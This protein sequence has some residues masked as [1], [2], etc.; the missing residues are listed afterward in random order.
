MTLWPVY[1]D[2]IS[3]MSDV[4]YDS[5][6]GCTNWVSVTSTKLSTKAVDN[7]M[8]KNMRFQKIPLISEP[9]MHVPNF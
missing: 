7:L 6:S 8:E 5:V 1:G 4:D 3:D 9:L 2:A